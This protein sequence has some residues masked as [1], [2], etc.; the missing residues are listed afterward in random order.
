MNFSSKILEEAVHALSSLPGIGKKS[1]L[2][3]ALHLVQDNT[4][5][6]DKIAVALAK[7]STD[8]KKCKIC[9]NISDEDVCEICKSESRLK[10]ILCVV[11]T[12]RDVM[13]IEDT[14][15]FR[16]FYHVLGGVIS[17]ME[18]IGPQDLAIDALV[19]R[20]KT[21]GIDELIMAVSPTIE[22]ETTI[23]YISKLVRD[24]NVKVSIIARGVAF[25]GELEYADELT[26]GRS[27]ATRV[28]YEL[29]S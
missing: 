8:I 13:A 24:M 22:G 9:Y 29:Q 5:K 1:A 21:G 15:Q 11:E 10:N 18:G 14:N 23:Y 25:G 26:L 2:R 6:S 27:I 3:L 4:H 19:N 16:G 20:I 7:L 17:P 12:A 28:P